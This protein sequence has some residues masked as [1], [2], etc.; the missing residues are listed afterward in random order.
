MTDWWLRSVSFF[1]CLSTER[2]LL[3]QTIKYEKVRTK[4]YYNMYFALIALHI[5]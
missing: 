4:Y 2:I 3:D 1:A 5:N